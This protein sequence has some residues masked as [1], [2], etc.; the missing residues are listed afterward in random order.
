MYLLHPGYYFKL[1]FYPNISTLMKIII[2][3]LLNVFIQFVYA[4]TDSLVLSGIV[5]DEQTLMPLESVS[6]ILQS[7][8]GKYMYDSSLTDNQ[9]RF[10]LRYTNRQ[11]SLV[12]FISGF[13]VK[14]R[15]I[16]VPCKTR[17]LQITAISQTMKIR[18]VV[19]KSPPIARNGDTLQYNVSSFI[20]ETD[21]KIG[22]VL[23]RLPGLEVQPNGEIRY[24]GVS[25]NKFYVEGIDVFG[26]RYGLGTNNI[27]AAD[28][29]KVE[30]IENHSP[31]KVLKDLDL[32]TRAAVNLKLKNSSKG[33]WSGHAKWGV[34]YE[35]VSWNTET[36]YMYL[37]RNFQNFNFYKT[38]NT[39]DD[40]EKELVSHYNQ[41][42][43]SQFVTS[44]IQKPLTP[45]IAP[46][47]Y[48][49]NKA[50]LLST[51]FGTRLRKNLTLTGNAFYLKNTETMMG[52]SL[53]TYYRPDTAN[54]TISEVVKAVPQT[55][56]GGGT[57]QM[58]LN[59]DQLYISNETHYTGTASRGKSQL[60]KEQDDISQHLKSSEV[61]VSNEF[62]AIRRFKNISLSLL[63]Y[64]AYYQRPQTLQVFPML[65]PE[66]FALTGQTD[67]GMEQQ[68]DGEHL[69][70]MNHVTAS[71]SAGHWIYRLRIGFDAN[72]KKMDSKLYPL[73]GSIS[74]N[75]RNDIGWKR[76]DAI[77]EPSISYYGRSL[78]AQ[79]SMPVSQAWLTT[80]DRIRFLTDKNRHLFFQ[81]SFYTELKLLPKL[82]MQGS[83]SY[84][85]D[86]GDVNDAYQ[87]YIMT[88]YRVISN[89]SG[90]E[91][92]LKKQRYELSFTYSDILYAL[93]AHLMVSYDWNKRNL[94]YNTTYEGFLSKVNATEVSNLFQGWGIHGRISKRFI[95]MAATI[96]FNGGY[97]RTWNE[98]MRQS[99]LMPVISSNTYAGMDINMRLCPVLRLDYHVNYLHN[100][101][102]IEIGEQSGVIRTLQQNVTFSSILFDKIICSINGEHY[103]NSSLDKKNRHL[104]FLNSSLSYKTKRIEYAAELR[105]LLNR[106]NIYTVAY[107]DAT[108][109]VYSYRLRPLNVMLSVNVSF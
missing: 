88:N 51:N 99:E 77:F 82:K 62:K 69:A 38:N 32:S 15:R 37:S 65:Y 89:K 92:W 56:K 3:I 1:V 12:I 41:R 9:G 108:S 107:G 14:P 49:D 104:F 71:F 79:L 95:P 70:L 57:F 17:N 4:Q 98:V 7:K 27:R 39:G 97:S 76:Q 93:F 5:Q 13:N 26:G 22:D 105:N 100:K 63:S 25:I 10:A 43:N 47:Y 19:I 40:Y 83:F 2:A 73:G 31:L 24:Q 44:N 6:V 16:T 59:T 78:S 33:V 28:I 23:K 58:E 61:S 11:D 91:S 101:Y 72:C 67:D 20:S 50:H 29:A 106:K 94:M 109:Y 86:W 85:E 75:L 74:S 48:R 55:Q 84:K 34:G 35:P 18:E 64:I 53:T 45:L 103:Y 102:N 21:Q 68:I 52:Q 66:I 46:A 90:T 54:W 8:D 80:K 87:G 96:R 60:V 36:L 81:P 30:V 42:T